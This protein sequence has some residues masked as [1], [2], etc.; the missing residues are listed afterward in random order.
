M[1]KL[2]TLTLALLAS[3]SVAW[4]D[5]TPALPATTLSFPTIPSTGWKGEVTPTYYKAENS[6]IYVFCPYELYQSVSN[7]TW[8]T[9]NAGGSSS[10]SVSAMSPFPASS[11]FTGYKMATLNGTSKGPYAYRVTNCLKAYIYVKSGSDKKRT[12]TLAAYEIN[13]GVVSGS[14]AASNTYEANSEG[15]ISIDLTASKEYYIKVSQVG[16]GSGG[17]SGGN[18]SFYMI[19]F[20]SIPPTFY[21]AFNAN[22]HGTAPDTIKNLAKDSVIPEANKPV[23]PTATGYT[24]RG[25]YNKADTT[26]GVAWNWG[27]SAI[28]KDTTLYAAWK[29]NTHTLTWNYPNDATIT[30]PAAYT[31]G[32]VAYGTTIVPPTLTRD[33]YDF[34]GWN[35]TPAATMP[36]NDLSYTAQWQTAATKHNITY[37]TE[38]LKGCSVTGYPTQYSEGIGI[39][40][41]AAL[42][43]IEGWHF[44]GWEPS[45]ISA[46]SKV[47]VEV[48]ATWTPTYS[49]TYNLNGAASGTLPTETAKYASEEFDL[50]AQGDIVAPAGKQFLGW[51][52]QDGNSF[53]AE[54]TYTMPAKAVTLYVHWAVKIDQVIY[55]WESP[56]GTPI[57]VGGIAKST[58][59]NGDNY[60]N[61][62]INVA[63]AEYYCLQLNGG[64]SYSDKYIVIDFDDAVKAG[65]TIRYTGFYNNSKS[66]NAAPKMRDAKNSNAQIFAGSNLPN[67]NS[68]SPASYKYVV[69]AGINTNKVQMT[70][71]QTGSSSFLT[72]LEIIRPSYI[73]EDDIYTV[74]FSANGGSG[75]MA[76]KQYLE[77]DEVS[78]PACTFSA[79]SGKEFDAWACADSTITGGKFTMPAKDVEVYPLWRDETIYFKVTYKHGA[80]SIYAENVVSGES[81]AEYN[82][83]KNKVPCS[84]FGGWYSKSDLSGDAV[85]IAS[86]I[87]TQDTTFY[88]SFTYEYATSINIE[89]LILD[90]GKSYNLVSNLGTR[91]YA[92]NWTNDL[93][94]L[95]AAKADSDRN[96]PYLGQK[97]KAS[98]KMIDFR[99]ANGNTVKVKFGNVPDDVKVVINGKDSTVA[100]ANLANPFSYTATEDSYLSIRSTTAN[101]LVFKQIMIGEEIQDIT[102]PA[103][104][105]VRY[106]AGAGEC[107]T[108]SD[109]VEYASEKVTLPAATATDHDYALDAWYNA[110]TSGTKVGE[111]GAKLTLTKD[112]TLYAYYTLKPEAPISWAAATASIALNGDAAT[113]QALTNDESVTVAYSSD[114]TNVAT[115]DPATGAI[116]LK[117]VG[118]ANII[119]TYTSTAEGAYKTTAV[120]YE[121]TVTAAT[122]AVTFSAPSDGTLVV[123][124][125]GE[126][127]TSGDKFVAGTVLTVE[128]N[129]TTEGYTLATLT[130]NTTDIKE[131]KT[132]T[133]GS[134]DVVVTATF[135]DATG[136]NNVENEAKA[137]KFIE[138]G[139]LFIRRGEKVYT[140]TGEE[141]K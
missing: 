36:D 43:D 127:I 30:N 57:E 63:Q 93:D 60:N 79:P 22:G 50:A 6:D 132:F 52:D 103:L 90:N 98:G 95:T 130:A 78:L 100:K 115:I 124:Q 76:S 26:Q 17:S 2:F 77:G 135:E 86:V 40:S 121:L 14:A 73:D 83:A 113:L 24:F 27:T 102:L 141:V 140:I 99:L 20:Q 48:S 21:M 8:T 138:N 49:V 70:R 119:A 58:E 118:S 68:A 134:V 133:I 137:V 67:I 55:S 128:A 38:S 139:Q 32:T 61:N 12:I 13:A 89:Q 51:K 65:D 106:E 110:A 19:A 29:T 81:P 42:A 129:A 33:G 9:Q 114:D 117:A 108:T 91:H 105:T 5:L 18:S 54:A 125:G 39:A 46:D 4:A 1:R 116:T 16:S 107:T 56:E 47:D 66:K 59:D 88:G 126:A 71:H 28:S 44:T 31:H 45:S 11:V 37:N 136:I 3:F 64:D 122:Y 82:S 80:D 123:K 62:Q 96:Y 94:S 69:P 15:V 101:T 25:W 35:E 72:K 97:A 10:G 109:F 23:D 53:D 84:S 112:T 85:T 120:N 7:L 75:S 111:V 74:S 131:S 92:T 34:T 87:I 41:F 104:Y